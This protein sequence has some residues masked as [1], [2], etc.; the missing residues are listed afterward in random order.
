[1]LL[2]LNLEAS[3][4]ITLNLLSTFGTLTFF[5]ISIHLEESDDL[6]ILSKVYETSLAPIQKIGYIIQKLKPTMGCTTTERSIS[7]IFR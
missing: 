5:A 7:Y 1:M 6:S 4:V 3:A 2:V